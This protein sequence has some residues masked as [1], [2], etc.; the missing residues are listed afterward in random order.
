MND[1][2][3]RLRE[4]AE[5]IRRGICQPGQAALMLEAAKVIEE[6]ENNAEDK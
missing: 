6:A 5:M 1:L 2:V 3:S 4:A